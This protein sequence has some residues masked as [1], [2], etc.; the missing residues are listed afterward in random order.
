[1]RGGRGPLRPP[2]FSLPPRRGFAGAGRQPSR[3]RRSAL[4]PGEIYAG[5]AAPAPTMRALRPAAP[6]DFLMRRKSPKTHQETPGSWT[7]G[8]RG[9]T[10]LDSP[11]FCPSGIGC[12]QKG[13]RHPRGLPLPSHGLKTESVPSMKPEEKNKTDLPTQLKVANR[14]KFVVETLLGGCGNAAGGTTCPPQGGQGHSP[15]TPLVPFVVKRKEPRVWA[16]QAHPW[17]GVQRGRSPLAKRLGCPHP[18]LGRE[19]KGA[20][21]PSLTTCSRGGASH[22]I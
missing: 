12:E 5:L 14:S 10:P 22:H 20:Q 11:G 9:Q 6:G 16:G 15:G 3:C 17:G 13:S 2:F 18:P 21:K 7:S 8:T 1:M 19:K 4:H